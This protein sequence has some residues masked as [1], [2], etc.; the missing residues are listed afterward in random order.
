MNG[1]ASPRFVAQE[2]VAEIRRGRFEPLISAVRY[3]SANSS[4]CDKGGIVSQM[5]TE[6]YRRARDGPNN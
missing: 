3:L 4:Q 1:Q 5:S 2:I 6:Q